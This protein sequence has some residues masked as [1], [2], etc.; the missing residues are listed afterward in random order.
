MASAVAWRN[1]SGWSVVSTDWSGFVLARAGG[2]GL[3]M[4]CGNVSGKRSCWM[5]T[6]SFEQMEIGGENCWIRSAEDMA[7]EN[8]FGWGFTEDSAVVR[9]RARV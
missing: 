4:R 3:T 1:E 6:T 5:G 8:R 7:L 9:I 2:M